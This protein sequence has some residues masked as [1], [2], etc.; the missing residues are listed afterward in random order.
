MRSFLRNALTSKSTAPKP[1]MSSQLRHELMQYYRDEV[2]ELEGL[3][4]LKVSRWV[5]MAEK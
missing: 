1:K 5:A 3:T 2:M 4:G